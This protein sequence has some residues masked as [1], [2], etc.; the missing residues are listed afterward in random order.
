MRRLTPF[1]VIAIAVLIGLVLRLVPALCHTIFN[2][3]IDDSF[4][5]F[6]IARNIAA[7][8]GITYAGIQTNGF[9]PLF[10]FM[11][12]PIFW[13]FRDQQAMAVHAILVGMALLNVLTG[14]LLYGFLKA[15][16]ARAGALLAL[17]VWL[18]SPYI[19]SNAVN[20]LETSL[21]ATFLFASG[22]LYVARIRQVANSG[23]REAVGLGVLLG[24]GVLS[25][26]D[27][28]FW[29]VALALDCVFVNR[30]AP[31][32]RRVAT[33]AL[34]AFV[35]ALI[36][37][38]W[39]GYNLYAFGH[40][41]PTSGAGVRFISLA[42]GYNYWGETGHYF[43]VDHIP[44][45]YY[46]LSLQT[47]LRD[48]FNA[49]FEPLTLLTPRGA[50]LASLA[51]L[52]LVRRSWSRLLRD[53]GYLLVFILFQLVAYSGY[54]FGQWFYP[55]YY[56]GTVSVLIVIAGLILQ[57][58]VNRLP[59]LRAGVL[60]V[61]LFVTLVMAL[62]SWNSLPQ[63]ALRQEWT[64]GQEHQIGLAMLREAVPAGETVGGFQS[65]ALEY[66]A[67]DWRVVNLDGVVNSFA[68]D[69]MRGNYMD[70]YLQT[71]EVNWLLDL[72]WI[73]DALY[74]RCGGVDNPLA[75]WELVAESGRMQLYR[76]L[77]D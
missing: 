17:V 49:F 21:T 3:L 72:D 24:L 36:C 64:A 26:I 29:A 40:L 34:A 77:A 5:A 69:A 59:D 14:A 37:A 56:F 71:E 22:W 11:A 18:A 16:K 74:V 1:L 28:G 6:S 9:Q 27:M 33:I 30:G 15:M 45:R 41:L 7:G 47:S 75:G 35:S 53:H 68:L 55:R 8:D 61:A 38:P 63:Q 66:F 2:P 43:P 42:F 67:T 32:S 70:N 58:L 50:V 65:V 73:I 52:F 10:V 48:I 19:C 31:V 62:F 13:I 25:R 4:Y 51:A 46:R 39:F 12:V 54:V 44:W 76:R 57:A 20:G 23:V 60:H